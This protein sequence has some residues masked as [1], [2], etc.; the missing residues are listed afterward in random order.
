MGVLYDSQCKWTVTESQGSFPSAK[1]LK[2][3][4]NLYSCTVEVQA[5]VTAEPQLFTDLTYFCSRAQIRKKAKS[6][7]LWY[8]GY[9]DKQ[10][11]EGKASVAQPL[12]TTGGRPL[13][14]RRL[15]H[16]KSLTRSGKGRLPGSQCLN[17]KFY[18]GHP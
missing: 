15:T 17:N 5:E 16:I 6:K 9:L 11:G 10:W 14:S 3:S 7:Y 13:S 1:G 8:G 18:G 2:D 12:V 4:P